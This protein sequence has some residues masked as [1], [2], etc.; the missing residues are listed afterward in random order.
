VQIVADVKAELFVIGSSIGIFTLVLNTENAQE[1]NS[2]NI[3]LNIKILS[4]LY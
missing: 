4:L 2:K 1:N 3:V